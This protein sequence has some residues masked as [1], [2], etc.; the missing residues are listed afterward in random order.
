VWTAYQ[1]CDTVSPCH[2]VNTVEQDPTRRN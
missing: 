2:T 1:L